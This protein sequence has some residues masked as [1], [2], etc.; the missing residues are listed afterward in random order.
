MNPNVAP[1][2][3]ESVDS[4]TC[5]DWLKMSK[6]QKTEAATVVL[7]T[8]REQGR[9]SDMAQ[10]PEEFDDLVSLSRSDLDSECREPDADGDKVAVS[11]W[12]SNRAH[13]G[14]LE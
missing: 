2:F 9:L 14:S 1:P 6:K 4:L 11:L 7:N 12:L 13:L 10:S 5:A 3:P 8:L